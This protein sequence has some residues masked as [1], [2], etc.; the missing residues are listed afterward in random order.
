MAGAGRLIIAKGKQV[1]IFDLKRDRPNEATLLEHMLGTTG[2]LR[3]PTIKRGKTLLVGFNVD[4]YAE[5]FG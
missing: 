2:N 4:Q 1:T 3:A 5:V